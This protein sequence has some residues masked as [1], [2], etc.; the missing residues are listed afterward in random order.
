MFYACMTLRYYLFAKQ[1]TMLTDHNNLLWMEDS[2]VPKIVRMRIYLQE[3]NFHLVHVPGKSNIFADWLSR[4]YDPSESVSVDSES[5]VHLLSEIEDEVTDSDMITSALRSVHNSRMGHHGAFRTWIL[6]NKHHTGHRIPMRLV[7]D[8]VRECAFCQKVR[9]TVNE[10]LQAPTR[11]IVADHPR[12]LCGY[13]TLYVT[14]ADDEGFQYVHVFKMLPSRLIA[15]YPSKT[16]S[17][18]SLATAAFQFFV[19]Y[20]ITDVLI[21]DPGSNITSEVMKLLLDWFGQ[22]RRPQAGLV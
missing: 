21:T 14:P 9:E 19:T 11:A 22:H 20:E 2:E 8:F 6:L 10:S 15:L 1:F 12:H 4:M 18:E 13:D 7:K 16:L 5:I 17:A 3:F